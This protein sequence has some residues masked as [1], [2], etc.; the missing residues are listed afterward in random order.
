MW[1]RVNNIK[2]QWIWIEF[3]ILSDT[4]PSSISKDYIAESYRHYPI[5]IET[6][7]VVTFEDKKFKYVVEQELLPLTGRESRQTW[8]RRFEF[9]ANAS[10]KEIVWIHIK[11][12]QELR[13]LQ[14]FGVGDIIC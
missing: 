7:K 11:Y 10:A 6:T 5:H 13:E 2:A 4:E 1:K 9:W 12:E 8:R 14:A 3:G